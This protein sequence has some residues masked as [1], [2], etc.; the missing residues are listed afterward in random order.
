MQCG[1]RGSIG[2]VLIVGLK[3]LL[4]QGLIGQG[5]L[6]DG[7]GTWREVAIEKVRVVEPK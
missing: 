6:D 4:Y 3:G 1:S 2:V 5:R 7:V